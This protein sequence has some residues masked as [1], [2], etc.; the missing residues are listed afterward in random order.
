MGSGIKCCH[1]LGIRDPNLELKFGISDEK[2]YL[3]TTLML[4]RN[5]H[6]RG[7]R[8]RAPLWLTGNY[9][10]KT[11][12]VFTFA[13]KNR[14]AF[15]QILSQWSECELYTGDSD[16]AIP[17]EFKPMRGKHLYDVDMNLISFVC[18]VVATRYS[19]TNQSECTFLYKITN[20][21]HFS[22]RRRR[23]ERLRLHQCKRKCEF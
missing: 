6:S 14:L 22:Q 16:W 9:M 10:V 3:V 19:K 12:F 15:A 2:I 8:I 17:N 4:G 11:L 18:F 20:S 1:I 13:N 5:S 21:Y 23:E 7:T